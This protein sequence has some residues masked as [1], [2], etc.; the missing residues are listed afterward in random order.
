MFFRPGGEYSPEENRE[1][2]KRKS[3]SNRRNNITIRK[4]NST[5]SRQS[6]LSLKA[7]LKQSF[8]VI[9]EPVKKEVDDYR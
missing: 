7:P 2:Q 5:E 4:R 9:K 8:M 6:P 3:G 1:G